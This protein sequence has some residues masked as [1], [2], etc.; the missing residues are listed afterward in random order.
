MIVDQAWAQI[1]NAVPAGVQGRQFVM[2]GRTA[3]LI[4][5]ERRSQRAL[6]TLYS[7]PVKI[8]E[9]VPLGRVVL[10]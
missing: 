1:V 5:R 7:V 9:S 2:S 6:V 3:A 10:K 8:D 4:E